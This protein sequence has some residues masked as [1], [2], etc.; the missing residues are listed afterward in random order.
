[1]SELSVLLWVLVG[2]IATWL[3]TVWFFESMYS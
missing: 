3:V 2:L 1:M